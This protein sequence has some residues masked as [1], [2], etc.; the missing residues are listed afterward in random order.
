MTNRPPGEGSASSPPST[1]PPRRVTL[2]DVAV[3]AAVDIAIVSR[4]VN[5]DVTLKITAST[6]DRVQAA[7]KETGYV[8]NAAARGL[9]TSRTRT[10]GMVLPDLTNPVYAQIVAGVQ[11]QAE[12]A[13][14]AIVLGGTFGDSSGEEQ[15]A[16]LLAEGRVDGLLIATGSVPDLTLRALRE[17]KAPLVLVNRAVDGLDSV[18][19][20]DAAAIRLAT[21]H[22]VEF[23]H[24]RIGLINGAA[25]V[26][27]S[28]RREEGFQRAARDAGLRGLPVVNMPSWDAAAG[29]EA[30]QR[31]VG[32]QEDVTAIVVATVAAT[33][34]VLHG[35][36]ML[37]RSVPSDVSV[38]A[39]HDMPS[40]RFEFPP[41]TIVRTP[42]M[43]MGS[44]AFDLL[45]S[46]ING[47][48]GPESRMIDDEPELVVRDS[49][50]VAPA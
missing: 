37:G 36:R 50:G 40:A 24:R 6:R 7:L 46:R 28:I 42:L 19:V 9:R 12:R 17:M 41:I 27:T 49:S 13:G 45:L 10:V 44:G 21:E 22:L 48:Q 16:R 20:D 31:L 29:L 47:S 8:P 14:Y 34:G 3:I 33:P 26:D 25:G 4:V 39:L 30:V 18:T 15:F 32:A 35:L 1:Q 5:N 38:V 2:K 23:G 43:A 11:R